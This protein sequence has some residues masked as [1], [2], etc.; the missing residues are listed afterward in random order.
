MRK[1]DGLR[2]GAGAQTEDRGRA[3]PG[4][5][6]ER[7]LSLRGVEVGQRR[8][9]DKRAVDGMERNALLERVRTLLALERLRQF[10]LRVRERVQLRRLLR[11]QHDNGEKQA[12]Q[13]ASALG[14]KN[15]HGAIL[16]HPG[17]MRYVIRHCFRP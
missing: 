16:V 2:R 13:R 5:N 9:R 17:G 7:A 14:E 4:V 3:R 8:G 15:R 12:L 6:P 1:S 11:E 10:V